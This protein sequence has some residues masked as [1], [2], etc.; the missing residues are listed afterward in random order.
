MFR[1]NEE[2]STN[3]ETIRWHTLLLFAGFLLYVFPITIILHSMSAVALRQDKA[4][5]PSLNI[6]QDVATIFWWIVI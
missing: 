4:Y 3:F 2:I 1:R 5:E 6:G